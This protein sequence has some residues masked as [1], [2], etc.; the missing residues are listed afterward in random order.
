M[1]RWHITDPIYFEKDIRVTVQELG[2]RSGGRYS[3][4][5]RRCQLRV[6]YF[7]LDKP[8]CKLPKLGTPDELEII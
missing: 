7:Y 6:A 1:Y 8:S 3:A 2:W 5:A 4:P